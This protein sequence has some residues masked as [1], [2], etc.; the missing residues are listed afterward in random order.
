MSRMKTFLITLTAT[1]L[2]ATSA[3]S[4]ALSSSL[5][6]M[7]RDL[8][9]SI[10]TTSPTST[11]NEG[12]G[13]ADGGRVRVRFKA[14]QFTGVKLWEVTPPSMS[15]SCSGVDIHLGALSLITKD[16]LVNLI[17][18][19][20]AMAP[21]LVILAIQKMCDGCASAIAEFM[22]K[23]N[24]F[25]QMT[26][27]RCED[28]MAKLVDWGAAKFARNKSTAEG[29]SG[30]DPSPDDAAAV[31]SEGNPDRIE[32]KNIVTAYLQEEG[33]E[34]RLLPGVSAEQA[35]NLILTL[36]GSAIIE[37]VTADD[38][39]RTPEAKVLKPG[40][41]DNLIFSLVEGLEIEGTQ[42]NDDACMSPEEN[43]VIIGEWSGLF[44][45]IFNIVNPANSN[46][47]VNR[48]RVYYDVDADPLQA[49]LTDEEKEYLPQ[50]PG[51]YAFARNLAEMNLRIPPEFVEA[52][53]K[54]YAIEAAYDFMLKMTVDLRRELAGVQQ[55]G[56]PE[57]Y[58]SVMG[59]IDTA[60]QNLMAEH[61]LLMA[62][63]LSEQANSFTEMR[64]MIDMHRTLRG[65]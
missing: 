45:P 19:I 30:E 65:R 15:A 23:A 35:R 6:D 57:V 8:K 63:V 56:G 58:Q 40:R 5:S 34:A 20:P 43:V 47:I 52:Q 12:A 46:S 4:W 64:T 3:Q 16:Q 13:F 10:R 22:E 29:F 42:C 26:F 18:Q 50:L 32:S 59:N 39:N 37:V 54:I 2:V 61:E 11:F 1:M 7:A 44:A 33:F 28:N 17:E 55:V 21:Y 48:M 9:E 41:T 38:G 53:A 25:G 24:N 60:Q 49:N 36:T 62:I 14:P 31:Q 51:V 27:G